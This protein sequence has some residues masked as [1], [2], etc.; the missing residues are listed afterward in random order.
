MVGIAS[1]LL[2]PGVGL[3]PLT[4]AGLMAPKPVAERT[5][6][7]PGAAVKTTVFAGEGVIPPRAENRPGSEVVTPIR[8]ATLV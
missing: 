7:D 4:T 6:G 1:A 8:N 3:V 2:K 5:T